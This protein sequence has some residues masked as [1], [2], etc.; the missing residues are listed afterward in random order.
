MLSRSWS[1]WRSTVIRCSL[2]APPA[3]N[4]VTAHCPLGISTSLAMNDQ[5]P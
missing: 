1:F 4:T 2:L 5:K 3:K